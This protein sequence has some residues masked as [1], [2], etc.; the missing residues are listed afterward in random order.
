MQLRNLANWLDLFCKKYFSVFFFLF[1]SYNSHLIKSEMDS[2]G[3]SLVLWFG[4]ATR[5]S[6]S[7]RSCDVP[8]Y[9]TPFVYLIGSF[10]GTLQICAA[11]LLTFWPGSHLPFHRQLLFPYFIPIAGKMCATLLE[12]LWTCFGR[13]PPTGRHRRQ[14]WINQVTVLVYSAVFGL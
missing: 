3:S 10:T 14:G 11:T 1:N 6:R 8:P 13:I 4:R 2:V 7:N 5:P 12:L 9:N